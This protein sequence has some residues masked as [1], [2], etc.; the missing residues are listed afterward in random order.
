MVHIIGQRMPR[1]SEAAL[2]TIGV[3]RDNIDG[4]NT[5]HLIDGN[6]VVGDRSAVAL[7]EIARVAGLTGGLPYLL[8]YL[9]SVLHR[10]LLTIE[11]SALPANHIEQDTVTGLVT[12][13]K[14]AA[15]V[16]CAQGPRVRIVG[17]AGPL[18]RTPVLGVET[19][20]VNSQMG[21]QPL[22][23]GMEQSGHFQHDGHTAGSVVGSHDR[24]LPIGR[25]GVVIGP[26]TTVPMGTEE[27]TGG[28]R[29]VVRSH[30]VMGFQDGAVVSL[31]VGPLAGYL[32]AV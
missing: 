21:R 13:R 10:H 17:H 7:G 24:L 8:Y 25:I 26:R 27:N 23:V 14:M 16:L 1:R 15:P 11:L 22:S 18:R 5:G 4:R 3:I 20:E 12:F 28:S 2:L 32:T 29:G 30:D 31:K 6:V 19:Y 9:R